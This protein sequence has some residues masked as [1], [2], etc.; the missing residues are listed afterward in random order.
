[1]PLY[2]ILDEGWYKPK[3]GELVFVQ[4]N[5]ERNGVAFHGEDGRLVPR[6]IPPSEITKPGVTLL[7][8][9]DIRQLPHKRFNLCQH[10]RDE[11]GIPAKHFYEIP[12]VPTLMNYTIRVNEKGGVR[13]PKMLPAKKYRSGD[14]VFFD[15]RQLIDGRDDNL[16]DVEGKSIYIGK[17]ITETM[18]GDEVMASVLLSDLVYETSLA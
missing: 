14:P 10:Q 1:M 4:N 16:A 5:P 9:R 8:I 17:Y 2:I 12:V 13:M 11:K 7:G 3:Q 18:M 15:V 6:I